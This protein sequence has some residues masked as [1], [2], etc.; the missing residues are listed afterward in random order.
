MWFRF[1]P[2]GA[3]KLQ[4]TRDYDRQRLRKRH[5]PGLASQIRDNCMTEVR[6]CFEHCLSFGPFKIKLRASKQLAT[7]LSIFFLITYSMY[8]AKS[9]HL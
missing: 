6:D 1:F 5:I 2:S 4:T 3:G 7:I 8:N 9:L